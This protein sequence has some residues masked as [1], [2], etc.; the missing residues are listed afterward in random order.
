MGSAPAAYTL[1]ADAGRCLAMMLLAP[2]QLVTFPEV[3][4]PHRRYKCGTSVVTRQ[5]LRE[6]WVKTSIYLPDDLAVQV[7]AYGISISE[8]AQTAHAPTDPP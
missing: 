3:I 4:Q 7:R 2:T 5:R 6:G 8:V 1:P